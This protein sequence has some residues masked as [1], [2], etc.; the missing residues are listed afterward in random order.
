MLSA[1]VP[2]VWTSQTPSK[3]KSI[4][5]PAHLHDR[6][7]FGETERVPIDRT[8]Q[9]VEVVRLDADLSLHVQPLEP[10]HRSMPVLIVARV[11]ES[12]R[13]MQEREEARHSWIKILD[14]AELLR[15]PPDANPVL[16]TV[17]PV[18]QIEPELRD[19]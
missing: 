6:I 18:V 12:L 16:Q 9:Q 17:N 4:S 14:L 5:I 13:V 19:R 1:E 11:V 8:T 10:L 3:I 7:S 15:V 2:W